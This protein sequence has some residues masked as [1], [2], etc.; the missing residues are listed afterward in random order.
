MGGESSPIPQG[1]VRAWKPEPKICKS[2]NTFALDIMI[3]FQFFS[4]TLLEK[5]KLSRLRRKFVL[6]KRFITKNCLQ[7]KKSN[8]S[9]EKSR[10]KTIFLTSTRY[11]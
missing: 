11:Y 5:F 4:K 2:K 8:L 9:D 3:N 7:Q 10:K 6:Y 1:T